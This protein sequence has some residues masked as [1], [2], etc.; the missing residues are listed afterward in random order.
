M[1]EVS[2]KFSQKE[3]FLKERERE[4]ER[5]ERERERSDQEQ[6]LG[7]SHRKIFDAVDRNMRHV[8]F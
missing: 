2:R 1:A 6:N 4:R 5:E 7:T 3:K 8:N